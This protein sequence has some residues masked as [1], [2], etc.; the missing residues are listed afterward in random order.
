M[1][2][3]RDR[4]AEALAAFEATLRKEPNRYR[5]YAGA[6]EAAQRSGDK[7]KAKSYSAKLL[8]MVGSGT[9]ERPELARARQIAAK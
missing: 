3:A 8:A 1:L 9:A 7:A 4:P 2:L 5:A 6:A